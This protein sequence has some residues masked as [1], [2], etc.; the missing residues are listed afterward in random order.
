MIRV[1]A[2]GKPSAVHATLNDSKDAF[3]SSARNPENSIRR[4]QTYL[5]SGQNEGQE[6]QYGHS[7]I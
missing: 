2:L 5:E 1:I 4:G 6:K 3:S 7:S